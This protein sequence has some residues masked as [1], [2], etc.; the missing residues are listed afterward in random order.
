MFQLQERERS[1]LDTDLDVCTL[2]R[3]E[4]CMEA[5]TF[6][7]SLSLSGQSWDVAQN[8]NLFG[9][10]LRFWNKKYCIPV[11]LV[12]L[13]FVTPYFFTHKFPTSPLGKSLSFRSKIAEVKESRMRQ[14]R[15]LAWGCSSLI[16]SGF[17]MWL[18]NFSN[19][20]L[21]HSLIRGKMHI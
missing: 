17:L 14:R 9:F 8:Y 19:P 3:D 4:V 12:A 21:M 13:L 7:F 2:D 16:T 5:L 15:Q 20:T 6:S 10:S 18:Y 1:F 11:F